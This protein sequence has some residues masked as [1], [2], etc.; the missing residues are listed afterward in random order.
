MKLSTKGKYALYAMIFLS[1]QEE[2]AAQSLKAFAPLGLPEAYLE[3]LLGALRKEGLVKSVRG[4]QGGYLLSRPPEKITARDVIE[5]AEGPISFSDCVTASQ[6]ACQK[7]ENCPA[8]GVW[9]YLT[10]KINGLLDS[11]TLSDIARKKLKDI[12]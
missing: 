6:G 1:Q 2:G 10:D 7:S 8:K 4:A 5:A 9:E 12:S 3:Q 11:I